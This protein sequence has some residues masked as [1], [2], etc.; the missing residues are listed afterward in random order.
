MSFEQLQKLTYLLHLRQVERNRELVWWASLENPRTGE[1][2]AFADLIELF[3]FLDEK[4]ANWLQPSGERHL[5]SGGEFTSA[6]GPSANNARSRYLSYFLR[7]LWVEREG[8][9]AW[10][11][12]LQSPHTGERLNFTD[13]EALIDYLEDRLREAKE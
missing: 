2:Q 1:R 7:L 12:S 4:T 9:P 8:N 11:V 5:S 10:L 13:L 6:L 3:A